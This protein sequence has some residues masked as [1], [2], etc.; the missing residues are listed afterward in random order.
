MNFAELSRIL[1]TKLFT[2]GTTDTTVARVVVL[3]AIA[4]AVWW[5]ARIAQR[6][7]V[8]FF[9]RRGTRDELA[10]QSISK[11]A[12]FI[13]MVVG[14]EVMLHILGIRLTSLFAAGGLAA[15]AMGFAAKNIVENFLSGI[16][17]HAE[18]TIRPDDILVVQNEWLRVQRLG[19][20][21]T[22]GVTLNG[23]EVLI[24]NSTLA[25]TIVTNFTRHNRK[26]RITCRVGV[27]Y[28]SDMR[29]VRSTLETTLA[30]LEWR[31]KDKDP[32]VYMHQFG[33]SSVDFL[34]HVWIDD[35]GR[36]LRRSSDLHEAVWW[37]LDE[38]EIEISFP[39]LDVHFDPAVGSPQ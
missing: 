38:A 25:Q 13:V 33:E 16:I 17:L 4:F 36:G 31:S 30:D 34:V 14:L 10:T 23:E 29:L 19:V 9:T 20:R 3:V 2:I 22:E 7:T 27:A 5:L 37:A 28:S 26:G 11:L 1:Q 6:L 15:V 8:H 32:A 24:P 35:I 18:Q 21:I 12:R 39:Q